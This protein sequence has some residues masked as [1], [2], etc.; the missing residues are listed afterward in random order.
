MDMVMKGKRI[1]DLYKRVKPLVEEQCGRGSLSKEKF[2][3]LCRQG[4]A[5][6]KRA[7]MQRRMRDALAAR[8]DQLERRVRRLEDKQ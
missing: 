5:L 3:E 7:E 6:M 8:I 4:A 2:R 1:D